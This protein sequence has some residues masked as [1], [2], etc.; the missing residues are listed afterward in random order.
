[1]TKRE[2]LDLMK[3]KP[4]YWNSNGTI[5]CSEHRPPMSKKMP[6]YRMWNWSARCTVCGTQAGVK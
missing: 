6:L 4:L 1:M 3:A 2:Q 5:G